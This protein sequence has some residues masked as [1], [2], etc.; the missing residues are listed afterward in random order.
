MKAQH[1][2]RRSVEQAPS[3]SSG[4]MRKGDP[5]EVCIGIAYGYSP[6]LPEMHLTESRNMR[7][8]IAL[9]LYAGH[10]TEGRMTKSD[11]RG[12]ERAA[13]RF[14]AVSSNPDNKRLAGFVLRQAR[15]RALADGVIGKRSHQ[16]DAV[17]FTAHGDDGTH[18]AA[19][20]A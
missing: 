1:T 4:S 11:Y 14:L 18:D 12:K 13:R 17:V 2:T 3:I 8:V 10:M 5:A 19:P 15:G 7:A 9:A 16:S 6:M 20:Q